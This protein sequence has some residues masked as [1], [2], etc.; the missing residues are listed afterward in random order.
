MSSARSE[1]G[2]GDR[3]RALCCSKLIPSAAGSP[4]NA[5]TAEHRLRL[6][7]EVAAVHDVHPVATDQ[8]LQRLELVDVLAAGHVRVVLPVGAS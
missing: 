3:R 8:R 4:R 5:H 1:S 7:E 6:G 2:I